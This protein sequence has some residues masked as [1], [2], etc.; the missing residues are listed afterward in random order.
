[1]NLNNHIDCSVP[2]KKVQK[3]KNNTRNNLLSNYG[4]RIIKVRFYL[5]S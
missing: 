3:K 5:C 2:D 4:K 1:M